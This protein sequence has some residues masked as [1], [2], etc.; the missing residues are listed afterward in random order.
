MKL[1][2]AKK[3]LVTVSIL[4]I[5]SISTA[6]S[7]AGGMSSASYSINT[8]VLSCGGGLLQSSKYKMQSTIGQ[9]SPIGISTSTTYVNHAG[10]WPTA[11]SIFKKSNILWLVLPAI[12]SGATD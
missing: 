12:L 10:F 9:P 6:I 2:S 4:L 5:L 11:N 3:I 1:K 8:D 7:F